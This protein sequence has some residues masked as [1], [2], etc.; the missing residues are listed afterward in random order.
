[1]TDRR[2]S[3]IALAADLPPREGRV[4]QL[5]PREIAVF[6]LGDRFFAADNR[7]PHKGGPLCDGI[8]TGHAVVCP[9]H[10][11]KVN[12]ETGEVERPEAANRCVQTYPTRVQDGVLQIDVRGP[13]LQAHRS[14]PTGATA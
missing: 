9:L 11:W 5:G 14:M 10:A 2:W 6:N 13:R 8:V 3:R 1:M 7:C 12:L 4:V